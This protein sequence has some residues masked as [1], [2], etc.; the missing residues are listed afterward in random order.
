MIPTLLRAGVAAGSNLVPS[1]A[2]FTPIFIVA[3][4]LTVG[5][6]LA[7]ER[8]QVTIVARYHELRTD[9]ASRIIYTFPRPHSAKFYTRGRLEQAEPAT[10]GR[11]LGDNVR[12]FFVVKA[13][14]LDRV[15]PEDRAKLEPVYALKNWVLMRERA[16]EDPKTGTNRR[17][18]IGSP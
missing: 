1:L 8:S 7:T 6:K 10:M 18:P 13:D 12:D 16:A 9:P 5:P 2:L 15:P 3:V 11:Y 14:E 17:G 4:L